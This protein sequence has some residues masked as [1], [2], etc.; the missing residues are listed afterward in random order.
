MPQRK[1]V[2]ATTTTPPWVGTGVACKL[3]GVSRDWLHLNRKTGWKQG[4]HW[5]DKRSQGSRKPCYQWHWKN[6]EA[7]LKDDVGVR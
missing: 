6:I 3:L 1:K 4:H 2:K 5:R 7:W